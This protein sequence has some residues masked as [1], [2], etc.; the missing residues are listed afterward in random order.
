MGSV[1]GGFLKLNNDVKRRMK[2]KMEFIKI[3]KPIDKKNMNWAQAKWNFPKLK[4]MG[5]W[6]NDGVKNQFDCR[7]MSRKRQHEDPRYG[8]DSK[9][10][11][12]M[13]EDFATIEDLKKFAEGNGE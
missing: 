12:K 5:D 13:T 9:W 11:L 3:K 4:P 1:V 6:D 10:K 8:S 7:P 2:N